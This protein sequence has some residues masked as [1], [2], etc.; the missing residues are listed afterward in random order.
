M[1]TYKEIIDGFKVKQEAILAAEREAQAAR[2]A[3]DEKVQAYI[4]EH[5][6]PVEAL[7]ENAEKIKEEYRAEMKAAFGIADGEKTN[8]LDVVEAI[9]RVQAL[10]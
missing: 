6:G 7:L 1:S 5:K 3:L 2:R 10:Q 4:D 8:V 9:R